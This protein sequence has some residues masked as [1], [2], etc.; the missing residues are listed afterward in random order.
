[1]SKELCT[2]YRKYSSTTISW[3]FLPQIPVV[4]AAVAVWFI[5]AVCVCAAIGGDEIDFLSIV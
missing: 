2:S 3:T 5:D 1:M 4:I